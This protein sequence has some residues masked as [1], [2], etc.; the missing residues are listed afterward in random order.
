MER[1]FRLCVNE[2]TRNNINP[3]NFVINLTIDL[4]TVNRRR[5]LIE[6]TE[7]IIANWANNQNK[8]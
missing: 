1:L 4:C 5:I 3:I 6:S 8:S 7:V 2:I